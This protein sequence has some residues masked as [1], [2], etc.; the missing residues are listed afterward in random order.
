MPIVPPGSYSG[1][2]I[3]F[4]LK[5]YFQLKLHTDVT[6]SHIV[7]RHSSVTSDLDHTS[8]CSSTHA[9]SNKL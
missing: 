5:F 8:H 4:Y 9:A 7:G 3:V 2:E 6:P 1:H